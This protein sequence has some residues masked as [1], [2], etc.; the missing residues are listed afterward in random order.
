MND[1]Y[2]SLIPK[3]QNPSTMGDLRPITLC[4]V[5]YKIL[6]KMIA[7]RLK[8]ILE[9]VISANQSAF[10]PGRLIIDNVLVVSEVIHFLNQKRDGRDGW[11]TFKFDMAKAYD[12]MEWSFLREMLS[13]MGFHERLI[14]LVMHCVTT[15]RYKL[16]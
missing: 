16:W 12:K 7:N 8:G 1:A 4:N 15:V 11:C 6:S 14:E 9:G 5:T 13:C 10:I 2:I 3:K